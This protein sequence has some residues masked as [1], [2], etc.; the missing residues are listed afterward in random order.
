[1]TKK[2]LVVVL[3][4]AFVFLLSD[5]VN[6]SSSL[7]I[8]PDRQVPWTNCTSCHGADL[9]GG[10]TGVACIECHNDFSFPDPPAP[11]HHIPGRDD[12]FNNCTACHG[13]DLMGGAGPSCFT[14]HGQLWDSSDSD[15][16]GVPDS[17]DNCPETFNPNQDDTYP[18]D[19]NDCGDACECEGNFDNDQDQ[20]GS[21]A[22]TFK[23]DFGRSIFLNPCTNSLS[24]NGDFDCDGDV[25]GT[26]GAKFKEDFG[27]SPFSNPCSICPTNPWCMYP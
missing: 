9:L 18:P 5:L 1:M 17:G 20:D 25:D 16:D 14:C 27:R 19:G 13:G 24:C 23:V 26:D 21:D 8:D 10:F 3:C 7:H 2:V 4:L 22:S 6:A 15:Q 12:P 11:G